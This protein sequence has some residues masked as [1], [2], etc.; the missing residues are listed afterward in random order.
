MRRWYYGQGVGGGGYKRKED[1]YQTEHETEENEWLLSSDECC[2][3][4]L[5][6][7][8]LTCNSI[9]ACFMARR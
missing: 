2:S 9:I 8:S 6:R 1:Q 3:I 5:R 7:A 4:E